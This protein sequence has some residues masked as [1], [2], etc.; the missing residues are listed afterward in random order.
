M[1]NTQKGRSMVEMLGV[2]AIIGVLSIGGIAGYTTSMNRYRANQIM[3]A[4]AKLAVLAQT[5]NQGQGGSVYLSD[6]G[7][8]P[9]N[10]DSTAKKSGIAWETIGGVTGFCATADQDTVVAT[11]VIS[12]DMKPGIE[13]ALQNI[14]GDNKDANVAQSGYDAD[15]NTLLVRTN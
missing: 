13:E 5:A 15:T 3:D 2:L 4:A 8:L 14:A 7:T 1:K 9:T 6:D 12:G 10:C 11:V